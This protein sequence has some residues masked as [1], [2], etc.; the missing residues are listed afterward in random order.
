M[1]KRPMRNFYNEVIEAMNESSR[2]SELSDKRQD[3]RVSIKEKAKKELRDYAWNILPANTRPAK[4]ADLDVDD[5]LVG[6][7]VKMG[8]EMSQE[9]AASLLSNNLEVI[10]NEQM[11]EESFR[12]LASN[13]EIAKR[14]SGKEK[15][16]FDSYN[17]LKYFEGFR[18][19]YSRGEKLSEEEARMTE[20]FAL[21]GL[22]DALA[23]G[24]KA[25]GYS[26][27]IQQ[28]ARSLASDTLHHLSKDSL[29]NYVLP[30]L[31]KLAFENKKKYA[32]TSKKYGKIED[33][34]K[35]IFKKMAGNKS[36]RETFNLARQ[37]M[38]A[39]A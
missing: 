27:D 3:Y 34:A 24:M 20:G 29:R 7:A 9:R 17:S 6:S 31:D 28:A 16:V 32:E 10:V 1:A 38:Y 12:K 13:E 30:V 14:A 22:G 26:S 5:S 8:F 4:A 35:E 33:V 15:S 21:K 25:E 18:S 39:A 2:I 37:L 19:R 36:D 23:Q 11:P